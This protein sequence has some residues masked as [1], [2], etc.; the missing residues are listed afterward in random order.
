MAF[1]YHLG[2]LLFVSLKLLSIGIPTGISAKKSAPSLWGKLFL[3]FQALRHKA[4]IRANTTVPH[5]PMTYR[6]SVLQI[7]PK[8]LPVQ[9]TL[10]L[11]AQLEVLPHCLPIP[12]LPPP[13]LSSFQEPIPEKLTQQ[14]L[15]NYSGEAKISI[16]IKR[17]ICLNP[18]GLL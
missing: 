11:P 1:F 7:K 3:A 12:P 16:S 18:W 10:L 8:F 2:M 15:K 13:L 5:C 9:L 6:K 4:N 17:K 14:G